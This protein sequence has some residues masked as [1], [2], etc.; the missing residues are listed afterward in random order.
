MRLA[1]GDVKED[2]AMGCS[3][4]VEA[5]FGEDSRAGGDGACGRAVKD[6]LEFGEGGS[7]GRGRVEQWRGDAELGH[8]GGGD[9]ERAG[10][11]GEGR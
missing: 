10:L 5:G 6:R 8:V 11:V 9:V 1:C 2:V 7:P 3:L 4:V